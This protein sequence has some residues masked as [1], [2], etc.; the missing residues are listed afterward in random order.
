MADTKISALPSATTPLAG[1]EVLPIVQSGVT[2]K[3]ANNDLRPRQIQSNATSGVL[4]VVGPAAAAT[5]VM[6]V[7]NAN[8][9][10]A[11]TDAAQTFTG[12]QSI[13]AIASFNYS[14]TANFIQIANT[15]YGLDIGS[16]GVS[17]TCIPINFNSNFGVSVGQI[18]VGATTTYGTTSDHRLKQNVAPMQGRLAQIMQL[19]PVTY[20]WKFDNSPGEGFIAHELAEVC[21]YAVVG[22]K[23]AVDENGNI[24]PQNIDTSFLIGTLVAAI[25]ELKL[26]FDAYV[27]TH[28]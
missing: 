27:A 18:T 15:N 28:P 1:T 24:K 4:Q 17:N 2:V 21:P 12:L 20:N 8:F 10:A 11:R 14:S 3:V 7:P 26:E 16:S 13:P 6:T 19:R 25:Q 9:T 5:R 23:D 22:E